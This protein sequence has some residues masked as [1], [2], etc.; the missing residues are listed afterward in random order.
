MAGCS[1]DETLQLSTYP[2]FK[3][4]RLFHRLS[5]CNLLSAAEPIPERNCLSDSALAQ[6]VGILEDT[7]KREVQ[8]ILQ[9][10]DLNDLSERLTNVRKALYKHT[11][12]QTNVSS[13]LQG[14]ARVISVNWI[15]EQL[16]TGLS[17]QNVLDFRINQ[18]Y[19]LSKSWI[20]RTLSENCSCYSS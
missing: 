18:T 12:K 5:S 10:W 6:E 16:P 3:T 17:L 4:P 1:S 15:T 14:N 20:N 2:P 13:I 9:L 7:E 8:V 11:Q 19:R